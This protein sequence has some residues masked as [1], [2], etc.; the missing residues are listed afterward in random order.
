MFYKIFA[1]LLLVY[2]TIRIESVFKLIYTKFRK[3]VNRTH[4]LISKLFSSHIAIRSIE[5]QTR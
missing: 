3:F 5:S 4:K 2:N 1:K